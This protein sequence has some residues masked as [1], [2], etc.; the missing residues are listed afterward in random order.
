MGRPG[1]FK[2]ARLFA[3]DSLHIS[4]RNTMKPKRRLAVTNCRFQYPDTRDLLISVTRSSRVDC[5]D[6][7]CFHTEKQTATYI[8]IYL[9]YYQSSY[10]NCILNST[11]NFLKS[12]LWFALLYYNVINLH[13]LHIILKISNIK[14]YI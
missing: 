8:Y 9:Q 14:N 6:A 13:R 4:L 12:M 3:L 2:R 7:S 1:T 10:N 11:I 5:N